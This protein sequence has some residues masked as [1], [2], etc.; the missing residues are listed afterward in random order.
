MT[1]IIIVVILHK[2]IR[3]LNFC[4]C[5]IVV[6]LHKLIRALDFGNGVR[7]RLRD[8]LLCPPHTFASP[9]LPPKPVGLGYPQTTGSGRIGHGTVRV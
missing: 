8:R 6:I 3:A 4:N 5:K 7:D 2:L 1:R 9:P